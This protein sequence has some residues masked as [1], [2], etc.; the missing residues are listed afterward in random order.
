MRKKRSFFSKLLW[1]AGGL[2]LILV[3]IGIVAPAKPKPGADA[4]MAA[5]ADAPA[6]AEAPAPAAQMAAD[7]P[8]QPV[9]APPPAAPSAS[10]LHEADRYMTICADSQCEANKEEIRALYAQAYGGDYQA[11]RNL[12]YSLQ[13]GS[14]AVVR[15]YLASCVWR[16]IIIASGA[17]EVDASDQANFEF[18]C[19]K[20]TS[21]EFV[22]AKAQAAALS[23]RMARH[24]PIADE[25]IDTTGLDGTAE[26]LE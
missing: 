21:G 15:S 7:V 13:T 5:K 20:L 16:I 6:A 26:P 12:A 24:D 4:P 14:A 3:I 8:P 2:F 25:T 18:V 23:I 22:Q 19:S 1:G 10:R 17:I 9:E 11:Q